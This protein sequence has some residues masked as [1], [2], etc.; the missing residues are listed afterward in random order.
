MKGHSGSTVERSN[1]FKRSA[2]HKIL[3]RIK[4]VKIVHRRNTAEQEIGVKSTDEKAN[5]TRASKKR[6]Q[7]ERRESQNVRSILID[8]RS[9][10]D[11]CSIEVR[12]V[13]DR[14]SVDAR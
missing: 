2:K 4:K 14:G 1:G 11:M 5:E 9:M 10:T 6:T 3:F 13:Y 7:N 12:Y 8:L